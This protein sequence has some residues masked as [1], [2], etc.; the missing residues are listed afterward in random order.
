MVNVPTSPAL[1]AAYAVVPIVLFKAIRLETLIMHPVGRVRRRIRVSSS[2][3]IPSACT[4]AYL[5]TRI[6]AVKFVL[7]IRSSS[8]SGVLFSSVVCEIPAQLTR[9]STA[10]TASDSMLYQGSVSYVARLPSG[11]GGLTPERDEKTFLMLAESVTSSLMK[12]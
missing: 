8:A 4:L 11:R 3:S 6:A 12:R 1:E 10:P 7:I 5:L 9:K 2:L